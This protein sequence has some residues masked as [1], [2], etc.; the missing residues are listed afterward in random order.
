[1]TQRK[2]LSLFD[3]SAFASAAPAGMRTNTASC[4][5]LKCSKILREPFLIVKNHEDPKILLHSLSGGACPCSARVTLPSR[6][7]HYVIIHYKLYIKS[8]GI[9]ILVTVPVLL[10]SR[11]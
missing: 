7:Y 5:S 8:E 10:T 1:M 6:L 2:Q 4:I 3:C 11:I 9:C